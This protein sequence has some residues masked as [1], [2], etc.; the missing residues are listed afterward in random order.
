MKFFGWASRCDYSKS[1]G[2]ARPCW[3]GWPPVDLTGVLLGWWL[4]G[5]EGVRA[6]P[7]RGGG[8]VEDSLYGRVWAW[9]R[10]GRRW[11]AKECNGVARTSWLIILNIYK[12]KKGENSKIIM[13]VSF[14][15]KN[16]IILSTCTFC[17]T[18]FWL[19]SIGN[20][21]IIHYVH[22]KWHALQFKFGNQQKNLIHKNSQYLL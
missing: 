6:T 14:W 7:T 19:K 3:I 15:F 1:A 4:L 5:R 21:I 13:L 9:G 16:M 12:I 22:A 8:G 20:F 10:G 2:P 17:T 18:L 11:T